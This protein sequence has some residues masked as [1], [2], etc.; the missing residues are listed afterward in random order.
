[1]SYRKAIERALAEV[2]ANPKQE[3]AAEW[4]LVLQHQQALGG[5]GDTVTALE[6]LA[7]LK[8]TPPISE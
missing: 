6:A 7:R 1:V 2:E 4:Q 8:A 5:A 3:A